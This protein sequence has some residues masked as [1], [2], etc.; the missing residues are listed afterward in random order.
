MLLAFVSLVF[1]LLCVSCIVVMSIRFLAI[2]SIMSLRFTALLIPLMFK[3]AS[4]I[5][6]RSLKVGKLPGPDSRAGA[7]VERFCVLCS[8]LA[9]LRFRLRFILLSLIADV[10]RRPRAELLFMSLVV[11]GVAPPLVRESAT[12]V[13]FFGLRRGAEDSRG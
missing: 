2:Q 5:S 11:G 8:C 13:G 3:E 10:D 7:S 9:R 12:T 6:S 4:S 1:S